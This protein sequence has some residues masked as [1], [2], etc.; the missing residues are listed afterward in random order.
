MEKITTNPCKEF[1]YKQMNAKCSKTNIV[2]V[3]AC[4]EGTGSHNVSPF[5]DGSLL[6][7]LQKS[8]LYGKFNQVGAV[9]QIQLL[10]GAEAVSFHRLGA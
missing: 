5:W 4:S 10:H 6:I 2:A 8:D 7:C 1:P 9:L 3:G